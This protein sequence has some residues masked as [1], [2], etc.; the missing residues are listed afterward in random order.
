M[1]M[2][3]T[4]RTSSSLQFS[5]TAGEGMGQGHGD[6]QAALRAEGEWWWAGR[7]ETATSLSPEAGATCSCSRYEDLAHLL[8]ING[9]GALPS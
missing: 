9:N 3:A 5:H 8:H 1:M 7:Q 6:W 4:I 2:K